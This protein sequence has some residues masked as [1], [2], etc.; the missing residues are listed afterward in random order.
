VDDESIVFVFFLSFE[1][2]FLALMDEFVDRNR[3]G[4]SSNNPRREGKGKPAPHRDPPDLGWYFGK[5]ELRRVPSVTKDMPERQV[6]M[7]LTKAIEFLQNAGGGCFLFS[8][9]ALCKVSDRDEVA[10]TPVDNCHIGGVFSEILCGVQP[11]EV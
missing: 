1:P 3:G 9:F 2:F 11:E 10:L 6:K 5:E 8:F 7:L 4:S